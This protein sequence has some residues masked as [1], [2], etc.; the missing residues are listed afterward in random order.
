MDLQK[1]KILIIDDNLLLLEI[2]SG[3]FTEA[4]FEVFTAEDGEKA[5][6][7]LEKQEPDLIILDLILPKIDGFEIL[8]VIKQKERLKKIPVLV[9]TNRA[10][11]EFRKKALQ[12]GAAEY[13]P[14]LN[15]TPA[16]VVAKAKTIL[17]N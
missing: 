6:T 13:L 5:L 8:K 2:Y 1:P 17:H 10:E 9:L 7:L 16:E 4:G 14:K 12:L 3:K 11:Y 15:F